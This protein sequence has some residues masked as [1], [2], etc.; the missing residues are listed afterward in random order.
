MKLVNIGKK[1]AAPIGLLAIGITAIGGAICSVRNQRQ[2]DDT[3]D[4]EPDE[5]GDDYEDEPEEPSEEST[6]DDAE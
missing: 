3:D 1:F 6:V 5:D 4:Y 2:S